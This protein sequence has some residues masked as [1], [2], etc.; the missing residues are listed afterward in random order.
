MRDA[1]RRPPPLPQNA[2]IWIVVAAL[3]LVLVRAAW[4]ELL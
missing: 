2:L 4:R 1:P 3:V